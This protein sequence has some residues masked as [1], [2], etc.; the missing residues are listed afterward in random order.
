LWW[1]L[2]PALGFTSSDLMLRADGRDIRIWGRPWLQ[3]SMGL[4]VDL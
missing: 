2:N 4:E 3:C 1:T